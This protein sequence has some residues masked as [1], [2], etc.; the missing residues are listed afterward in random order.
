MKQKSKTIDEQFDEDAKLILKH[1]IDHCVGSEWYF[2]HL[3]GYVISKT[4]KL[5]GDIDWLMPKGNQSKQWYEKHIKEYQR[6]LKIFGV[7]QNGKN[8]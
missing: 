5:H 4:E 3:Q 7:E 1:A 2:H 6:R 8:E